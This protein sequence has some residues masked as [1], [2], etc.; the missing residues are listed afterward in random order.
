MYS[1]PV[2]IMTEYTLCMYM[3]VQWTLAYPDI[4][5]LTTLDYSA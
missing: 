4:E 1:L 3:Y 5:Y 2:C